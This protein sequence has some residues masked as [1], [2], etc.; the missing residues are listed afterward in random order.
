MKRYVDWVAG[1]VFALAGDSHRLCCRQ[2]GQEPG[3][4]VSAKSVILVERETG[5]VLHQQAEHE[6]LEPASVTKVM[7]MLVAEAIDGGQISMDD[8]VT[9]SAYAASMGGSQVYLEEGEGTDVRPRPSQGGGGG[10]GQ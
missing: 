1:P 9:C 8:Q 4:A 7:T 10:L 3:V 5:T 2:G 6:K